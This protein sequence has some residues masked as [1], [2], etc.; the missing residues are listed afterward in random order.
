MTGLSNIT[1]GMSPNCCA[2]FLSESTNVAEEGRHNSAFGGTRLEADEVDE[3]HA[4]STQCQDRM[5]AL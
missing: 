4:N 2:A 1:D 5:T 3:T